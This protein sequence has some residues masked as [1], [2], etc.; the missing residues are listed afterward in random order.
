MVV[1]LFQPRGGCFATGGGRLV[2]P[3]Y[4]TLPV[5]ISSQNGHGNFGFNVRY[6]SGTS[7][8]QGQANYTFRGADGYDYVVKSTSWQD[9]GAAF[10]ATTTSFGGV[11]SVTVIDPSNGLA[12][13]GLGGT[14]FTFRVDLST[15]A[16]GGPGFTSDV[17][18][19]TR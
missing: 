12:V 11:A 6:A 17:S 18:A 4:L 10:S 7:T 3:G 19:H 8:P 13:S 16:S 2:D 15:R 14:N 5:A 9:G 1:A